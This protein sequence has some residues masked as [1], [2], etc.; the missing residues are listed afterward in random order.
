MLVQNVE[1]ETQSSATV[2]NIVSLKSSKPGFYHQLWCILRTHLVT[3]FLA[4]VVASA[5]LRERIVIIVDV[6]SVGGSYGAMSLSWCLTKAS[7][8]ERLSLK[9]QAIVNLKP[10]A[11]LYSRQL[12]F[13]GILLYRSFYFSTSLFFLFSLLL[14]PM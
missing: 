3:W 2:C 12:F 14:R 10:M 4:V 11:Y 8:N 1:D 9:S 5:V 7:R 13:S 6:G